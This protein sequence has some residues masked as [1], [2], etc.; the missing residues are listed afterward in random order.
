MR[1]S[2][3]IHADINGHFAYSS[4]IY[5]PELLDVPVVVGGNEEARHG[6][7]LSKNQAAK[8]YK[9]QTGS[10]LYQARQLCP[11]LKS[12]PPVYPLYERTSQDFYSFLDRFT[13]V[14]AP[15]GCDG[16]SIDV[17]G[18]AHLYGG[19]A[20]SLQGVEAIVRELHEVFP[21]EYGLNLSIGVSWNFV[22]AKMACDTAGPN[23]VKW[24]VRESPEDTSWQ[25]QVYAM[26]VEEL[27]YI[28][29]ATQKKLNDKGVYTLGQMVK[30]GPELLM[31]WFGKVGL[32]HYIRATGMDNSPIV[33]ED[34]GPMMRS[35]GNGSTIPYDMTQED[36]AHIMAHVLASSVC[37]R[38]RAHK[39]VPRTVGVSVTYAMDNDLHY[40]S[41]QCPMPIPSSLDVEFAEIALRLFHKR[42]RMKY[43]IRKLTLC[44]RDLMF[45]TSVYQLSFEHNAVRREKAMALAGSVDEVNDR[46]RRSVKR[47]VELADPRLT[48]LGSKANQQ[49]APSGWY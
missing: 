14:S 48:D 8:K 4:L 46:W 24:I 13:P 31:R 21:K 44:G 43:P 32:V 19:G 42:F 25:G 39:V 18:T 23:G 3:I 27:L 47:C 33:A 11:D 6:I 35:I 16:K 36:Q 49:F 41:Y 2:W 5:Y 28:G 22:F 26:P 20:R 15:F 10:S 29:G 37:R 12:L 9:I 38:M 40:E 34:G 17:T 1:D 7:V 30:C 45:N